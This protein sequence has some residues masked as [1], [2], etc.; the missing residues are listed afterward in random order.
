VSSLTAYYHATKSW[1]AAI[2]LFRI[3]YWAPKAKLRRNGYTWIAKSAKDWCYETA[4]TP[5]QYKDAVARLRALGLVVTEQ[6]AF[7]GKVV[8]YLRLTA[9]G[10]AVVFPG[11]GLEAPL[12]M[13]PETPPELGLETPPYIQE[14]KHNKLQ[15]ESCV[16]SHAEAPGTL[17]SGDSG[18]EN[19]VNAKDMLVKKIHKPQG[20]L[21]LEQ[22]WRDTIAEIEG[23]FV[24]PLTV[25]ERG[26]LKHS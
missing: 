22:V 8:T 19:Q 4:L 6:H 18:Q 23:T 9:A 7:G 15:T 21:T 24:P 5:Q 2:L 1:P 10:R 11:M 25:K 16:Q 20:H 13:G 17:P 3:A 26:Q 14:G 12:G